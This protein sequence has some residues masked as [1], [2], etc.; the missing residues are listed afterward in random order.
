V[1]FNSLALLSNQV[2]VLGSAS[3]QDLSPIHL[4]L[5][6]GLNAFYR[7]DAAWQG[8]VGATDLFVSQAYEVIEA[9][10]KDYFTNQRFPDSKNQNVTQDPRSQS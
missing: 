9:E 5:A 7:W 6:T 1:F 8:Y 2:N 4:R 10:T 3:P